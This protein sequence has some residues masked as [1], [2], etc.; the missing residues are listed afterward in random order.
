M[1]STPLS[2]GGLGLIYLYKH[3]L[4]LEFRIHVKITS[5]IYLFKYNAPVLHVDFSAESCPY[6]TIQRMISYI[7]GNILINFIF[8]ISLIQIA[9]ESCVTAHFGPLDPP[10]HMYLAETQPN[11][12]LIK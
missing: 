7:K 11:W 12:S 3:L 6:H 4:G 8:Y 10:T 9:T 5:R 2:S 1:W